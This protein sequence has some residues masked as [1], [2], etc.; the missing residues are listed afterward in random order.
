ML[1]LVK[2]TYAHKRDPMLEVVEFKTTPKLST[3]AIGFTFGT[4]D[5]IEGRTTDSE[6]TVRVYTPP[7]KKKDAEFALLLT[8]QAL[9]F[10][11]AYFGVPLPSQKVD[12][13]AVP[14]HISCTFFYLN[15]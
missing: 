10:F 1:Q 7:G 13:V 6:M 2:A 11:G 15:F 5:F 8:C 4:F 14:D 3:H 12:L 9:P